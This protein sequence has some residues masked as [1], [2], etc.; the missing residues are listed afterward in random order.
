M[1]QRH[2]TIRLTALLIVVVAIWSGSAAKADPLT[3]HPRMW[4]TQADLPK[5]RSWAV[6]TNPMFKKGLGVAASVAKAYADSQWDWAKGQP[7]THS[8]PN[9]D[10]KDD[11]STS[12]VGDCTEAYAEMFAFMSLV[13]PN[14]AARPQWAKRSRIMLMYAINKALPGPSA[15][16]PFRDPTFPLFN[17]ANYWGEAWGFT[18]DWIYPYLS[19]ADKA[20]IQTVFLQWTDELL[21]AHTAGEEHPQPVGVVN[22]IKLLGNDPAMDAFHQQGAQL[23]MRWTG[24]NYFVG[25][26]RALATMSMAFDAADDPPSGQSIRSLFRNA[27]G[28]WLYQTYALLENEATVRAALHDN[29]KNI[30]LGIGNSGIPVESSLYGESEGWLAE[31]LLAIRTAGYDDVKTWG[32]Q[33][34]FFDSSYWD[35][36]LDALLHSLAPRPYVPQD[37]DNHYLGQIW[38]IASYGDMIRAWSEADSSFVLPAALGVADEKTGNTARLAKA[39]W[40]GLNIP[41]GGPSEVYTRASYIWGNSDAS[42]SILHFLLYDPKAPAPANPHA[43]MPTKFVHLESPVIYARTDWT[44]NATWFDFRC[45]WETISHQSGDC[46]QFEFWRKGQWLT[47]QWGNY[48]INGMGYTPLYHNTMGIQNNTPEG[49]QDLFAQ[50]LKYGGQWN[51]GGNFGDA[52]TTISV[53]DNWSYALTDATP[54]YNLPDFYT[55]AKNANSVTRASRSIVWISPD[56]VVTYDREATNKPNLFKRENLVLVAAPTVTGKTARAVKGGQAVTVQ[57]LLP[58]GAT[59]REEHFWIKDPKPD[60]ATEMDLRDAKGNLIERGQPA[61]LEP[62]IDRLVIEDPAKPKDTRFLTVIQGTDAAATALT[63]TAIHSS[64]GVAF[65]GAWIGNTAVMFPVTVPG[66]GVTG[67]MT[68]SVPSTVTRQLIT[69][70]V[71]GKAYSVKLTKSGSHTIVTLT[72]GGALAADVGGVAGVGFPVSITPTMGGKHIGFTMVGPQS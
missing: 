43:S 57:S 55:P 31:T 10:W 33:M 29:K 18:V 65:D 48:G 34:A 3:T 20:S 7:I 59:V 5:L 16:V 54:L 6:D 67:G 72:V 22:S 24:D 30:S 8:D 44:A 36:S 70:L 26:M 39:R 66:N 9:Q 58:A 13:D 42:L 4:I 25:H 62:A 51:D 17:R 35:R 40:I 63:A 14:T 61:I 27:S 23:Q 11:G 38:P 15:G 37:P 69:G 47:K 1:E 53:N 21:E 45:G 60:Y 32:P 71:P 64:A 52:T 2:M 49:L 19:S 50:N 68:Y 56:Y 12:Y 46:G 41:Q 28:A